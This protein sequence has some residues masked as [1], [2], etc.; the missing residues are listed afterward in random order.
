LGSAESLVAI[1]GSPS[2]AGDSVVRAPAT[3]MMA[4]TMFV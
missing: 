1:A 2:A 3:A 4:L